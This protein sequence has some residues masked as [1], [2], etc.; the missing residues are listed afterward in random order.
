MMSMSTI[1][2]MTIERLS[3]KIAQLERELALEQL[4]RECWQRIADLHMERIS[5]QSLQVQAEITKRK[6][7][8]GKV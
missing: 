1:L 4:N 3:K 2:M 6:K 7:E 5:E 8:W